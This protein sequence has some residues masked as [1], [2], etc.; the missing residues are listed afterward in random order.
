MQEIQIKKVLTSDIAEL[1]KISKN[2]F[3]ETFAAANTEE[4][5]VKYLDEN[6]SS[7]KLLTEIENPDTEF[8]F[9][10]QGENIVGYIK[11]NF[12]QSQ[13]ELQDDNAIEIERIYLL[14]EYQGKNIGKLLYDKA[15]EIAAQNHAN[16]IWLGV[17][18]ENVRAIQFYKKNGFVEFGKHT[19]KLGHDEQTDLMM[20]LHLTGNMC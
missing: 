7:E 4:N 3:S 13:T 9:A 12:R 15:V 1:Q 14:K 11:L 8:Y 19:F 17:W 16:Y 2:T 6:F 20:K 18:E 10:L 5:M